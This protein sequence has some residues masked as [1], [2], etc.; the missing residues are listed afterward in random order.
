MI[1]RTW[2]GFL[3]VGVLILIVVGGAVLSLALPGRGEP[4]STPAPVQAMIFPKGFLWGVAIA[5]QQAESV[6]A[7][8]WTKFETEV[9]RDH[10][11]AQGNQIGA[12]PPGDIHD[13][14]RWPEQVRTHKAGFDLHYDADI[15]AAARL[16]LNAFRVSIEWARL[17]PRAGMTEP[18]PEAI[19]YY[20]RIFAA[21]KSHGIEPVVTLFHYVSPAW[22]FEADA[23]GKRGW[24]RADALDLWKTYVD[25]VAQNF[26]PEVRIWC[27]LNEPMVY[28]Y[29]GYVIGSYPPGEKRGDFAG[30]RDVY[31]A[32]LRAHVEA[33]R[34]LHRVASTLG[35]PVSVG[36]TQNLEVF[37]PY[38][39]FSPL[40][41]GLAWV[42]D[43]AWN[44]DFLDAVANGHMRITT[45]D[46]DL[47]IEDLAGT[48]DYVGVN[49]YS[50][51]YVRGDWRHPFAP[52]VGNV[53]PDQP[54]E[55]HN[56]L[57]WPSY[58]RGFYE[59]LTKV[60]KRY[61]KPVMILENGTADRADDDQ[62]RQ[63][64]LVAHVREAWLAQRDGVDIRSYIHW[65]LVDNFEWDEGF[66]ARFGLIAV[67]YDHDFRRTPRPSAALYGDI[68]HANGLSTAILSRYMAG[69]ETASVAPGQ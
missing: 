44:W 35:A 14:G 57:G 37:E 22:F 61:S 27:T 47:P 2:K 62:A 11:F 9:F 50:R 25:A 40:D 33:Y 23:K 32:L 28:L 56:D 41:R 15:D 42:V 64:Y 18:D 65:S 7:S 19:A 30:T 39:R 54:G 6:P 1:V 10:R 58:P 17:F 38:N 48:E 3:A 45:T 21:M 55:E 51:N 68:A 49:Y 16:G 8:D 52:D 63:R 34:T 13:F 24:E 26:I 36:L 66:D 53:A 60:G 4:R 5:G 43:K 29:D 67:D 46:I 59:M 20:H 12:T 69:P 31:A